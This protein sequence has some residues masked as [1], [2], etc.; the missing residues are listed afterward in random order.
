[1]S[2]LRSDGFRDDQAG[3]TGPLEHS[4]AEAKSLK[5][6]AKG[7]SGCHPS[8]QQPRQPDGKAKGHIKD[9]SHNNLQK[10][11]EL[12]PFAPTRRKTVVHF[13]RFLKVLEYSPI[14]VKFPLFTSL[15]VHCKCS[16]SLWRVARGSKHMFL[17]LIHGLFTT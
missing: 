8:G 6:E 10:N 14:S 9:Y 4:S 11:T 7:L 13:R 17:E 5:L 3:E 1:M 16:L 12:N 15:P 2:P